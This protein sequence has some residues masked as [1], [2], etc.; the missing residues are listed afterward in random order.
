MSED[1]EQIVVRR[2]KLAAL[3]ASGA[4]PF[5]N[6]FRPDHSAHEVHARFGGL[7]EAGLA[8]APAVGVAGRVPAP[9]RLRKTALLPLPDHGQRPPRPPHPPPPPHHPPPHPPRPPP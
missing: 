4:N 1:H 8:A 2:R 6:D 7:D 3:R 9:P 5:P